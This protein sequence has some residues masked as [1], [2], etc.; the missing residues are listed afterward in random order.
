MDKTICNKNVI[1]INC[2][3]TKQYTIFDY[4]QAGVGL[5]IRNR[6]ADWFF[7]NSSVSKCTINKKEYTNCVNG[8]INDCIKF[9]KLLKK[10]NYKI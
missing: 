5:S 2:V 10:C 8:N 9:M 6:Y 1:F 3:N 7:G 4:I